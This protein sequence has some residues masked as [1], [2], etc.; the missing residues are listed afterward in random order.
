MRRCLSVL[1]LLATAA[2]IAPTAGA[3]RLRPRTF[4]GGC[5][6]DVTVS[7]VPALTNTPQDV[8][9]TAQ[10][11]GLCSGTFTDEHGRSHELSDARIGYFS[12]SRAHNASCLN[13][14]NTGTGSLKFPDGRLRFTFT[15]RRAAAFPTLQYDGAFGG[16]A[17]GAGGPATNAD[18]AAAVQACGGTGLSRFEVQGHL[19]TTPTI[20]G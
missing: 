12:F 10:G 3:S 17:F 2:L 1:A 14:L 8:D 19:Q 11:T 5:D 18:P 9:Q 15:E 16:S 20:S 4:D 6:F 7:F 13:G